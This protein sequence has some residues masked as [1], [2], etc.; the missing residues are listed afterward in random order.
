MALNRARPLQIFDPVLTGLVRAYRPEGFIARQLLPEMPVSK[1]SGQYPV[2]DKAPWFRLQA[3][4]KIVDKAPAR[5]VDYTWSTEPYFAEEY[6]LKVSLDELEADQALDVLQYEKGKVE[7]LTDQME[8]AHELRVAQFFLPISQGGKFPTALSHTPG[9]AWDNIAGVPEADI[10]I[11]AI[12]C[13]RKTGWRPT[14]LVLDFEVAYAMALNP[15]IRALLRYDA[16]GKT[17]DFIEMG[18][19]ILPTKIHGLTVVVA[20]GSQVLAGNTPVDGAADELADLSGIW[21]K[22]ARLI[23]RPKSTPWGKPA[24]G[25]LMKHTAKRVTRWQENDPEL[26]YVKEMERYDIKMT[27]SNTAYTILN[28]IA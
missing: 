2:F 23:F 20:E 7:F 11:A 13:Y 16:T 21:G 24:S 18:D 8:L 1:L 14:H 17:Q 19:M 3:D 10:K 28:V 5:E 6:A 26:E 9:V 25:Y 4:N 12:A 15:Q 27:A 22:H